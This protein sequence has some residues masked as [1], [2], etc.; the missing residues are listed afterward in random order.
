MLALLLASGFLRFLGFDLL[1][2]LCLVFALRLVLLLL[3]AFIFLLYLCKATRP[4]A[5]RTYKLAPRL[6]HKQSNDDKTKNYRRKMAQAPCQAH[7]CSI[8][9][10]SL[11]DEA[12][13]FTASRLL[14]LLLGLLATLLVGILLL[15]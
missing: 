2:L 11:W 3:L 10:N 7:A 14:F 1:L 12:G 4:G 15:S 5:A 9:F 8:L 6:K 13:H